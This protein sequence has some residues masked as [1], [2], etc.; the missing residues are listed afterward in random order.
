LIFNENSTNE[1]TIE[2]I[3]TNIQS[4]ESE[5]EKQL[6]DFDILIKYFQDDQF[7]LDQLS[8]GIY[9]KD[10]KLFEHNGQLTGRYDGIFRNLKFDNEELKMAN[11]EY[12]ILIDDDHEIVETNGTIVKSEK[13]I[14]ISW[15]KTQKELYWKVKIKEKFQAYSLLKLF[16]NWK[17]SNTN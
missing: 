4:S 12:I 10:R 8:D 11:D 3:Y 16:R 6:E 5:S 14:L 17:N 2:V 9:V 15:P 1:G 13:N 7:L